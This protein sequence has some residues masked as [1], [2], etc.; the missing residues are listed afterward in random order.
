MTYIL[1]LLSQSKNNNIAIMPRKQLV[2]EKL[3]GDWR[4]YHTIC[5]TQACTKLFIISLH[6]YYYGGS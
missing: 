5:D 1:V 4:L 3:Y 2:S 6:Y